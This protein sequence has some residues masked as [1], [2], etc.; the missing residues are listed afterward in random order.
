MLH[1]RNMSDK[2]V[3]TTQTR[4]K[5]M[6]NTILAGMTTTT[7]EKIT[8]VGKKVMWF[9]SGKTATWYPL[10]GWV[11]NGKRTSVLVYVP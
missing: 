8:F 11:S 2:V 5:K 7:N 9:E 4:E 1:L 10:I 3:S 6:K